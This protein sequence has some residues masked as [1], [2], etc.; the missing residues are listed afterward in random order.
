MQKIF[1][2]LTTAFRKNGGTLNQMQFEYIINHS[3]ILSSDLQMAFLLLQA[4]GYPI[5]TK[6]TSFILK[7]YFTPYQND[8]Y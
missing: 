8:R 2:Q 5:E 4:S 7:P 6:D 1:E 3:D